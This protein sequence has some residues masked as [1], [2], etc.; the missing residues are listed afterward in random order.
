[1]IVCLHEYSTRNSVNNN[2]NYGSG[3]SSSFAY[4]QYPLQGIPAPSQSQQFQQQQYGQYAN[5]N[6]MNFNNLQPLPASQQQQQLQQAP[7]YSSAANPGYNNQN[8]NNLNNGLGNPNSPTYMINS[9]NRLLPP[10]NRPPNQASVNGGMPQTS[11]NQ[12]NSLLLPY[13][14]VPNQLTPSSQTV[15]RTANVS[16]GSNA[17]SGQQKAVL[18]SAPVGSVNYNEIS[19]LELPQSLRT[20]SSQIQSFASESEKDDLTDHAAGPGAVLAFIMGLAMSIIMVV[21]VGCR[22]RRIGTRR[23]GKN[24]LDPDYLVDGMYL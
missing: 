19:K 6:G 16:A 11:V 18:V 12:Q 24:R 10:N 1:M 22:L 17:S 2:N 23:R 3:P 7:Y 8:N 9:P 21:V 20:L 14:G 4:P 5:G 15:P 13:S